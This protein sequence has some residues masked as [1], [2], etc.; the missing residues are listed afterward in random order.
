MIKPL[1]RVSDARAADLEAMASVAPAVPPSEAILNLLVDRL[2]LLDACNELYG[3]IE[4]L[5]IERADAYEN[6]SEKHQA[7]MAKLR[8]KLAAAT[9][10]LEQRRRTAKAKR[11]ANARWSRLTQEQRTAEAMKGVATRQRKNTDVDDQ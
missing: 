4:Q 3:V 6:A 5:R 10:E 11:A 9:I 2:T 8:G 1:L 7:A